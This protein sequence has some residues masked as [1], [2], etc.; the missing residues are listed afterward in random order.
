MQY[1]MRRQPTLKELGIIPLHRL[2]AQLGQ[3]DLAQRL[4]NDPNKTPVP[5]GRPGAYRG[6]D[7][8]GQPLVQVVPQSETGWLNVAPDVL[9]PD[10]L[11]KLALGIPLRALD[12]YPPL[13]AFTR[14][15]VMANVHDD[16]P[17]A[18]TALS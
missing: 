1:G 14:R 13:P 12:T 16:G 17:R 9:P 15:E 3:P 8:V 6:L 18:L 7:V 10:D 5:S 4:L 11:G 2:R